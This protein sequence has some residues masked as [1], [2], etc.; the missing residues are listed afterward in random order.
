MK[1]KMRKEREL[2]EVM[3]LCED[4]EEGIRDRFREGLKNLRG[5]HLRRGYRGMI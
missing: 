1:K 4:L 5:A 3:R 2:A